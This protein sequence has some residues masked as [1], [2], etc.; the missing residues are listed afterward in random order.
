MAELTNHLIEFF[1]DGD[2]RTGLV[3]KQARERLQ[4]TDVQGKRHSVNSRQVAVAHSRSSDLANLSG[5]GE[6]LESEVLALLGEIDTELLWETAAEEEHELDLPALTECYFGDRGTVQQSAVFRALLADGL[7]FKVKGGNIQVRSRE[8]VEE[9]RLAEQRRA[10]KE[11]FRRE[12]LAWLGTV[13][14]LD[15]A[16]VPPEQERLVALIEDFLLRSQKNEAEALLREFREDDEPRAVAYEVLEALGR[17]PDDADP[18]VLVAGLRAEFPDK[19]EQAAAMLATPATGPERLDL[20]SLPALAIDDPETREVDDAF[21]VETL[22]DGACRVGIHIA[23]VAAFVQPGDELD[24]EAARRSTTVYLPHRVVT[25]FPEHL[26]CELASLQPGEPHPAL[27]VL[28]TFDAANKLGEWS[29]AR[30]TV[31]IDRRLT[32]DEADA[33]LAADGGDLR[34]ELAALLGVADALLSRR[35]EAGALVLNRPEVKVRAVDGE[36]QVHRSDTASPSHRLVS[37]LMILLNHLVATYSAREDLPVI[38]RMQDA[39]RQPVTCPEGYDPVAFD[40]IFKSLKRS[41]FSLYPQ[42]HAGLGIDAYTQASSPIRRY[43]DLA[44]QRQVSARLAGAELPYDGQELLQILANAEAAANLSRS[45]ERQAHKRYLLTYLA[46]QPADTEWDGLVVNSFPGGAIV[47][48]RANLARGRL[49][50]SGRWR[51]GDEVRVTRKRIRPER[52]L[53]EFAVAPEG[54]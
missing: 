8:Q 22:A 21:T 48:L 52:E 18:L 14:E 33:L 46:A 38:Y 17:L 7:R 28:A 37:E 2:L 47:E 51:P 10:E 11:A 13:A 4:V 19:V 15:P 41:R 27:S 36:I 45:L 34:P 3:T 42:P 5:A 16:V 9:Q 32:Y 39:P 6:R 24:Q 40:R 35:R 43:A 12:S 25:M 53:L 50:G 26:S 44:I 49:L 23:D 54:A 29:L 30:T 31:R 20:T 1:A